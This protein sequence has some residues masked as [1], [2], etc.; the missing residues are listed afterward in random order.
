MNALRIQEEYN[1]EGRK[2]KES[3]EESSLKG[4]DAYLCIFI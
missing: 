1:N 3:K 2:I 4:L